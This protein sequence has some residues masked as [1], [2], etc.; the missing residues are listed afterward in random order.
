MAE[1]TNWFNNLFS[2]SNIAN[3][4]SGATSIAASAE[5]MQRAR[6]IADVSKST[7]LDLAGQA[8]QAAA[9]QPFTITSSP[10]LG[11]VSVGAQGD[12]T[13]TPSQQQ[14]AM[15]QQ[16]LGGAQ[17]VLGGLLTG[18]GQREQDIYNRIQSA[19]Q[20]EVDRQQAMLQQQMAAQGRLGLG[21]SLYGGGSPEE[22]ARQQALLEQQ[23]KDYLTAQTAAANELQSQQGLLGT[24][25]SQ[26]YQ[27]QT[28]Q[29]AAL[30][31]ATPIQ[32]AMQSGRLAGGEAIKE[33]IPSVLQAQVGA[34]QVAGDIYQTYLKNLTGML[35]PAAAGAQQ[36]SLGDQIGT[37]V[38]SGLQDLYN[39]IF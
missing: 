29:L 22:F 5:Q 33:A 3:A 26:A 6:D 35:S 8:S 32:Q 7:A 4:L 36:A 10:A 14:E 21:S 16:A 17:S 23:S 11:S 34:E 24:L 1:E 27:P 31:F 9:F 18:T 15:T 30:Q 19:R 25:T 12:I 13:L 38:S 37:A 39:R 20:P 2:G 28:Q